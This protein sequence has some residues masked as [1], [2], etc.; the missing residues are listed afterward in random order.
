MN[1]IVTNLQYKIYQQCS[2]KFLLLVNINQ[3][4][5]NITYYNDT[6]LDLNYNLVNLS[7]MEENNNKNIF[8]S[9]DNLEFISKEKEVS[10]NT[11]YKFKDLSNLSFDDILKFYNNINRKGDNLSAIY[12]YL[13][14]LSEKKQ[15]YI[16]KI[17]II[18]IKMQNIF[19]NLK[20]FLGKES[21]LII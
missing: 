17:V 19:E 2:K 3:N 1:N 10:Y 12:Y 4:H 8:I 13:Y 20:N 5:F 15:D 18:N 21:A 14:N 16:V 7:I 6:E 11:K 9:K